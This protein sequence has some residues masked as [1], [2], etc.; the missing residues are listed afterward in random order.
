MRATCIGNHRGH[1]PWKRNLTPVSWTQHIR[2]IIDNS[3]LQ[4]KKIP[5]T[6]AYI[7]IVI[8]RGVLKGPILTHF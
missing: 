3:N 6:H 5:A 4:R 8:C 2:D 1:K 7:Y